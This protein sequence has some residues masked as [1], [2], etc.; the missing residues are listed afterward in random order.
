M[1]SFGFL[2]VFAAT[3]APEEYD[4]SQFLLFFFNFFTF[5][6]NLHVSKWTFHIEV[7]FFAFQPTIMAQAFYENIKNLSENEIYRLS[8]QF[9]KYILKENSCRTWQGRTDSDGYGEM[10]IQF[11][12]KR[13]YIKVHRVSYALEH[14]DV[15]LVNDTHDISHLCHNRL[16]LNVVYLSHEPHSINNNRLVCKNDGD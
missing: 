1:F 11:R 2:N 9:D 16:C 6:M 14:P 8:K 13:L 4:L 15:S 7:Q 3:Y 12:G 10:Q 5:R